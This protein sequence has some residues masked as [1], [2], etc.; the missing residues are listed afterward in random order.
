MCTKRILILHFVH[1]MVIPLGKK[2]EAFIRNQRKWNIIALVLKYMIRIEIANS[3]SFIFNK[4]LLKKKK[5]KKQKSTKG[6]ATMLVS[7]RVLFFEAFP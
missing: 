2:K 1:G 5:K 4:L 3:H 6:V 7:Q